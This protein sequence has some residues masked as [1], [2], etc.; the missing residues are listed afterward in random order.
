MSLGERPAMTPP[1]EEF[2][3]QQRPLDIDLGRKLTLRRLTALYAG[4]LAL[5]AE[6]ITEVAA[7]NATPATLEDG[8][9]IARDDARFKTAESLVFV[10]SK[11]ATEEAKAASRTG[12]PTKVPPID[13]G[14]VFPAYEFKLVGHHPR[15]LGKHTRNRAR[16]ANAGNPDRD[17]ADEVVGRSGGHALERYLGG[18]ET[19]QERLVSERQV[20]RSLLK[21]L[22]SP[23]WQAHYKGR[24]LEKRREETDDKIHE[25]AEIAT[26]NLNL[27]N[28]AINGLHAAI[29][30]N[31]YGQ[32][33]EDQQT[34]WWK[35]YIIFVGRYTSARIDRL[36]SASESCKDELKRYQPYLDRKLA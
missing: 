2:V 24:N 31:L 26:V 14:V 21:D 1:Y 3:V 19:V 17:E 18:M 8:L 11:Y 15:A 35:R 29:R 6:E 13:T 12:E 33:P 30:Y 5:P 4:D 25:A 23:A 32:A 20:L 22:I 27:G 10:D 36:T 16:N 28:T 34:N 9:Y 7:V